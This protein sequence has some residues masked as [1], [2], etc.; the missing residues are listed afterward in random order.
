MPFLRGSRSAG[1]AVSSWTTTCGAAA[2][3]AAA[4]ASASKTSQTAASAPAA[5][6]AAARS[7]ERVIPVTWWPAPTSAR[8]SGRP[9]TPLAPAT[10][11]F[12]H[13]LYTSPN[14]VITSPAQGR[15]L[16]RRGG[17]ERPAERELARRGT[18]LSR[19]LRS[20]LATFVVVAV[21]LAGITAAATAST[22]AKRPSLE[23]T[24]TS[25]KKILKKDA[26]PVRVTDLKRGKV[27]LTAKSST[28]DQQTLEKLA[29]S[30]TLHAGDPAK[31]GLPLTSAGFD[32]IA[33][34]EARTLQVSAKGAGK[35]AIDLTRNTKDCKPQSIDLS[36]ATSCDF[37]GAQDTSLCL[38]PF[39]D[40]YYTVADKT[41][42]TG[43]RVNLTDGG[44]PENVGGTPMASTPYN[45]SDGF[46]PGQVITLRVPGLDNTDAFAAT[47]P[48]P[49]N[50]LSRNDASIK[51]EPIV[52]IDATTGKPAPIWVELDSNATTRQG[53]ALLIHGATQFI[54]GHRYIVAM[55]NLK[56]SSGDVLDAPAGFRYYRDDLPSDDKAV[57]DQRKRFEKV[58]RT[59]RKAKVTRANL[60]LAWDFTVASDANNYQRLIHMRDDAFA[61]L[62]DT[63]LADGIVQG[64]T[65]AFTVDTVDTNPDTEVARRV[66]G[67]FTVP[68]YLTNGCNAPAV[69]DLDANGNPVQQGTYTANYD[70]IIPHAAVDDPGA[71]PARPSLYGHGLLGSASEA[72][73]APQRSLAQAHNFVFC[74]TDEIGFASQD[75]PN[76]IG[77]L[78]DMGRFPELT[79]RTQ[80]GLLNE[81]LL[82]RLMDNPSGFLSNAA[83]HTDGASTAS[84][85][86]ID[87]S[88]LYYNGN[89]QGGILG[90]SL[91]A[92]SPDFTRAALG[93]PGIGYSTLLT[94]SIDF[95][96]YSTILYPAYPNELARPLLLSLVQML[97]DRSEP[98]GYAQKMTTDP[99]PNTP[100]HQVL[101]NVALG[102]HQVT[103]WQ[104]EVEARTIGASIH[105]PVVYDGRWPG[106]D[107]AWDIPAI[108][109]YPFAG[110]AIVYWDGGPV[111]DDGLGGVL[112]TDVPPLTNIPNES[113]K[114]PH[115]LPRAQPQEQQMV[116][117]FLRPDALSAIT[118]TCA[119]KP[120]YD[121]GFTGP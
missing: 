10:N 88:K 62:G 116:S 100:A 17:M 37:I 119:G 18:H 50:Q 96:T 77:I 21:A 64:T 13:A 16:R 24:S 59:L 102:D 99:L 90:G 91:T 33:S 84:P 54:S 3:T 28:F 98:N 14:A 27:T 104:A 65:P 94:R 45:L 7:C 95:K 68:C 26:I 75:V 53:T 57:N 58:F 121:G 55:R 105:T 108:S 71:S 78:Q 112:G 8:T 39:P 79:D 87:T 2:A 80:Q 114:D 47:D 61:Q 66:R 25:Q 44:M 60:Y 109:G 46:S 74:A 49:L 56:D 23:V 40:D 97:W 12:T 117:D 22:T 70:C 11:I 38:L 42:E 31:T 41:T 89:S 110:S 20:S 101:L 19:I 35:V 73:S 4:S 30:V 107:V 86:V 81:L 106:V 72:N 34:C 67:T 111:R 63:N 1:S 52:V 36:R 43:R 32:A 82:G 15:E 118:D 103:D 76:T 85:P 9:I 120:C 83:F 69:F 113:G 48:L 93:V 115:G 29:V 92:V 51:K 5:R 6:I